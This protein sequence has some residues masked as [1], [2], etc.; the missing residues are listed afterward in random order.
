MSVTSLEATAAAAMEVAEAMA[1]TAELI[2]G[3]SLYTES[4]SS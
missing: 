2:D 4:Q 1:G 3:L